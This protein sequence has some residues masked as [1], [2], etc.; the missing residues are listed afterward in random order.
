MCVDHYANGLSSDSYAILFDIEATKGGG[1]IAVKVKDSML[2]GSDMEACLTRAL[3]RMN[4]PATALNMQRGVRPQSR[5]MVVSFRRLS[6]PLRCCQS[7]SWQV[8]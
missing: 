1:I 8:A 4:V 6:L 7:R 5:S 3:E 2:A